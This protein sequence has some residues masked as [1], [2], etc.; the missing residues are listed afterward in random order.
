MNY[1]FDSAPPMSAAARQ[2]VDCVIEKCVKELLQRGHAWNMSALV[3]A[4][5][6]S[7]PILQNCFAYMFTNVGD[8]TAFVNGMVVFPSA[9]PATA[10]GD[11]RSVSG[12]WGDL[13]K[14]NIELKFNAPVGA[15]PAVEIV[16]LFYHPSPEE[17]SAL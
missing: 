15:A 17:M 8:T 14:G 9:T 16:Q 1:A 12:H 5:G 7:I 13:Y 4:E 2:W 3:Y 6:G 11:S 10:L